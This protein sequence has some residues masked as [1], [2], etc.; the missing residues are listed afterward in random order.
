MF[1]SFIVE[2]ANFFYNLGYAFPNGFREIGLSIGMITCMGY[3]L[4]LF[5]METFSSK[6]YVPPPWRR[7]TEA[8]ELTS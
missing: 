6:S 3:D 8:A 1:C 5:S 4:F 7:W 2:K